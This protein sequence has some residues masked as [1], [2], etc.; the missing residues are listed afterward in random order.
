MSETYSPA[1]GKEARILAGLT[2]E[3]AAVQSGRSYPSIVRY[4]S[5]TTTPS[6]GALEALADVYGVPVGFF[7]EIRS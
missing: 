3:Q 7:F 1:R 2:R 6:V 4:E 5:G